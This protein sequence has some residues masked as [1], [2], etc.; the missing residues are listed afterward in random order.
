MKIEWTDSQLEKAAELCGGEGSSAWVS[1]GD[2]FVTRAPELAVGKPV[3]L[4]RVISAVAKWCGDD[5]RRWWWYGASLNGFCSFDSLPRHSVL[6]TR[7]QL[8]AAIIRL[9]TIA[10][11]EQ[12][13]YALVLAAEGEK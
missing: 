8:E 10:T 11:P 5:A 2:L 13:L 3:V 9:H 1:N 6:G 7:E 12:R 4:E